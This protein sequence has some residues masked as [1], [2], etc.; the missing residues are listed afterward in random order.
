VSFALLTRSTSA[1]K[2]RCAGA[3]DALSQQV[4]TLALELLLL[5]MSVSVGANS[6]RL[7]ARQEPD[8]VVVIP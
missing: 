8:T 4:M 6:H 5:V 3:D 2:S 1:E 7:H